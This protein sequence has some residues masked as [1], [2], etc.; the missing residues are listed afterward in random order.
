MANVVLMKITQF[1]KS[2]QFYLKKLALWRMSC[3]GATNALP[4][5]FVG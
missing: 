2:F 1:R 5:T 4:S 3:G